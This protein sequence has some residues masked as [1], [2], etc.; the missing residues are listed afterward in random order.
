MIVKTKYGYYSSAQIESTKRSLRKTIFFLL[1]YVDPQTSG[2]YP[3]INVEEAFHS[4]QYKLNGLNSILLESPAIVETMSFL[5]AAL[6]EYTSECFDW[7]RYRKLILDAG[8]AIMRLKEG[9]SD[10]N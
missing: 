9:D 8:S 3:D 1:L 5:E 4:L 2:E 7:L 10:G 6:E